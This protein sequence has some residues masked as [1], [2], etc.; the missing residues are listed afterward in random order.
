MKTSSDHLLHN[1]IKEEVSSLDTQLK[2]L[3]VKRQEL[4]DNASASTDYQAQ[5]DFIYGTLTNFR[6]TFDYLTVPQKRELLRTI[7]NHIEWDGENVNIF[8]YGATDQNH[9]E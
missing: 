5:Y 2:N 4:I 1:Y 8:I 6:K 7:I 3:Q 9:A